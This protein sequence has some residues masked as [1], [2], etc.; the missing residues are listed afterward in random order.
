MEI[1]REQAVATQAKGHQGSSADT[2]AGLFDRPSPRPVQR[3]APQSPPRNRS[4]KPKHQHGLVGDDAASFEI[5][6]DTDDPP[7]GG[8][9]APPSPTRHRVVHSGKAARASPRKPQSA[10][11]RSKLHYNEAPSVRAEPSDSMGGSMVVPLS[12][13]VHVPT[14]GRLFDDDGAR[15]SDDDD[16]LNESLRHHRKARRQQHTHNTSKHSSRSHTSRRRTEVETDKPGDD[17]LIKRFQ[18]E[19]EMAKQEALDAKKGLDGLY[20]CCGFFSNSVC[21]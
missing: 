7:G 8:L 15:N 12:P 3:S 13:S 10:G 21:S 16:D 14:G 2:K 19:A 4:S 20:L 1:E 17:P 6:G 18:N 5:I 11:G 9:F